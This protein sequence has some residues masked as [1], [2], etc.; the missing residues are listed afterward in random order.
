MPLLKLETSQPLDAQK[1]AALLPALSRIVAE[2]IGKPEE[3]VMATI[4]HTSI[5]MSAKSGHAAF[6]D[7][8]SIGGL[9][10]TVNQQISK[11]VC[12]LLAQNLGIPPERVYL[13]FTN[14]EAENWGWN[15]N[16]FA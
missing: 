8:R 14:V 3:Y 10:R 2:S 9:S 15:G 4:N 1:C 11:K 13:N 12:S 6:V 5:L 7:V 16:T